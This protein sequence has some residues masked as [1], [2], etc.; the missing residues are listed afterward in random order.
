MR[1][2]KLLRTRFYSSLGAF[3]NPRR[4]RSA[5]TSF[6]LWGR[7]KNRKNSDSALQSAQEGGIVATTHNK[8]AFGDKFKVRFRRESLDIGLWLRKLPVIRVSPR[9]LRLLPRGRF[10]I[11][12]EYVVHL[13][14][15]LI[16]IGVVFTNFATGAADRGSMLYRLFSE[17]EIE[18]GPLNTK[19][20]REAALS[21]VTGRNYALAQVPS[22]GGITENDLE[23]QL[24]NTL[25]GNALLSTEEPITSNTQTDQ[26]QK[27]KSTF[28]YSVREGDT[29]STIAAKYGVSTNT[30]LWANGIHDGDTIKTGDILVIL[31]VTGVLH[32]V[33]DGDNLGSIAKKYNVKLED[34]A[35][36]NHLADAGSLKISQKLIIPDG[37]VA[38]VTQRRVVA[39][40]PADTADNSDN[41]DGSDHTD[42]P[43][44]D[45]TPAKPTIGGGFIWPTAT[46]KLS[47]YYGWN[48]TGIDIPNRA[49]PP[50]YAAKAGT[51]SFSGWLG[52]YGHLIIVDHGNSTKTYY[53]HLSKDFVKTGEVVKQGEVIGNVGSTGRS[54]GPHLHFE[55][56]K[57]GKP[58]NPLSYF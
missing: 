14:V 35:S 48:H 31:P 55:I 4:E 26:T 28:A 54:T 20:L 25:D 56:R 44:P 37:Y 18:E 15:L 41:S 58:T 50:V 52:G 38:P 2:G 57:N 23:F 46:K 29:P 10:S 49:L 7:L 9:L 53:A 33:K 3:R 12:K 42:H 43:K 34:I 8:R 27:Q 1:G 39:Q 51:V 30:I 19:A 47:Q 21:S 17:A 45:E 40:A 16:V 32:E 36:E 5:I 24:S 6:S 22:S 11:F 13:V